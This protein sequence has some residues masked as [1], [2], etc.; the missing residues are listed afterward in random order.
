[1]PPNFFDS[2]CHVHDERMPGGTAAAIQQAR[3]DRV[4]G[5][6]TVGCDR[7]TSLAA[8]AVA[9][10][11]DDVWATVGLHPHD[12]VQGV[13]TVVDLL[14]R[15]GVIAV[16][17][18]GLDYYYE[19]SPRDVQRRAFAEQIQLA[20][21][22]DL[23]LIIHSRDAWDDTFDVLAAEGTPT[24]TIFH[25][26]TGGADEAHRCLEVG[27]FVSFSGIVTFKSATDVQ[28]AA[29]LV[30]LDR[31]LVETDAPYL[32]PVPYRG[33]PNQPA[34]VSWTTQ[35]IAD[36]RDTPLG[37]V[38]W[39]TTANAAVAFPAVTL[40]PNQIWPSSEPVS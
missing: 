9:A 40:P 23:P 12:A 32:A 36:L 8:I 24:R 22:R 35:F 1:V 11:H 14:D 13:D 18:A 33:K 39:A 6:I 16:G 34:Y 30:P 4:A 17:E 38:A 2:H 31:M 7:P 15:P 37:M 3:S 26:F 19:H 5:M 28:D 21:E 10:E 29:R 25:C 20:H 27:A